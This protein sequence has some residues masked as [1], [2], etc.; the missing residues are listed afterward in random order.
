M[1][2]LYL[3]TIFF[4]A[5]C[6]WNTTMFPAQTFT[7]MIN[8]FGDAGNAGRLIDGCYERGLT[9]QCAEALK[10]AFK[11]NM[12]PARVILTRFAGER[13][14][15]LQSAHFSNRLQSDLYINIQF[16]QE[17]DYASMTLYYYAQHPTD[18]WVQRTTKN[19]DFIPYDQAYRT[20]ITLTRTW[21]T[22]LE[23]ELN[24]FTHTHNFRMLGTY[25]CP[26]KPLM[27]IQ[28]PALT[29]EIGLQHKDD[30]KRFITPITSCLTKLIQIQTRQEHNHE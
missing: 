14:E 4:I 19:L 15:P 25:P 29:V 18:L 16:Y 11:K 17:Q 26:S 21:V 10:D 5:P 24:R 22:F 7:C 8:P 3:L 1:R 2:T 13:L 6:I 23:K 9:L 20:T 28:A 12:V 27:G 30:W